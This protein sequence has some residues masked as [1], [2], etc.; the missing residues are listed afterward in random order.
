MD[1]LPFGYIAFRNFVLPFVRLVYMDGPNIAFLGYSIG[2]LGG[3]SHV[4]VCTKRTGV[5]MEFWLK[6]SNECMDILDKDMEC[7]IVSIYFLCFFYT[8]CFF[9][10]EANNLVF[11]L[12]YWLLGQ[13]PQPLKLVS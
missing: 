12:V 5:S 13:G 7:F 11:F 8:I 6:H 3:E 2:G 1:S 4:S 9:A 10:R